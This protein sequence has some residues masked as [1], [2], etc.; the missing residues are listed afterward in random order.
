MIILTQQ[1]NEAGTCKGGRR[2][3]ALWRRCL[4]ERAFTLIEVLIAVAVF[5]IVL[6]ALNGI[7]Y[8]AF[9]LQVSTTQAIEEAV[10]AENA[11]KVMRRDLANVVLP[12]VLLAGEMNSGTSCGLSAQSFGNLDG[13]VYLELYNT[14]GHV[15]DYS[16]WGDIQK[17]DYLLQTQS[18]RTSGGGRNLIRAVYRNLLATSTETPDQQILLENVSKFQVTFFDGT[19][20]LD[21]WGNTSSTNST[22]SSTNSSSTSSLSSTNSSSSTNSVNIPAAVRIQIEIA[23]DRN[24]KDMRLPI[25]LM[26][27]IMVYP[28]S[29]NSNS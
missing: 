2:V 28:V 8:G 17:V 15:D 12:G 22:S 29:T 23:R 11:L 19:N 4:L 10:P 9:H 7:Y 24:S 25:D 5:A 14:C 1:S 20:W 21:T 3:A 26:V 16:P 18:S 6:A 13:T 27:P